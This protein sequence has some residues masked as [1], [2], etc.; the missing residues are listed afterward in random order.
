MVQTLGK[1]SYSAPALCLSSRA[2]QGSV[3]SLSAGTALGTYL[4]LFWKVQLNT[5]LTWTL[6]G[7]F[8]RKILWFMINSICVILA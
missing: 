8:Q 5:S 4:G 6:A 3:K 7:V 1:F 2:S